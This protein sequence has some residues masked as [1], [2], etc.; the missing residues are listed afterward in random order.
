MVAVADGH[1]TNAGGVG[2]GV[3]LGDAECL[4]AQGYEL[5]GTVA[6]ALLHPTRAGHDQTVQLQLVDTGRY[7]GTVAELPQGGWH[8][9]LSADDWRLSGRLIL[10]QTEPAVLL[11]AYSSQ[12]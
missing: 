6:L 5:P 4:Q 1:G 7:T 3:R 11:P 9:Q 8:V 10:P 12:P 2:A